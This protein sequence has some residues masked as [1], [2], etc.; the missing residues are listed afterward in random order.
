M[1]RKT[2]DKH[3]KIKEV[4]EDKVEKPSHVE[5]IYPRTE[6]GT[7]EEDVMNPLLNYSDVI[8]CFKLSYINNEVS[9]VKQDT[10]RYVNSYQSKFPYQTEAIVC[11]LIFTVEIIK[12]L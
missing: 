11:P 1:S 3:E 5:S 4:L 2:G 9:E 6:T 8:I 7:I 10:N 12:C